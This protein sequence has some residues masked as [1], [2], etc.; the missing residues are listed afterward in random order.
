MLRDIV[1][2]E[3]RRTRWS[4]VAGEKGSSRVRAYEDRRGGILVEF[5]DREPGCAKTKRVRLSL[6]HRD[7]RKAKRKVLEIASGLERGEDIVAEYVTLRQLFDI[8]VREVTPTKG[9]RA[10][11]HDRLCVEMF[12]RCFGANRKVGSLSRR[13]W[14]QFIQLRKKG[15]AGPSDRSVRDRQVEY[16]LKFLRAVCNWATDAKENGKILLA[17]NP[18]SVRSCKLPKEKNPRRPVM[19]EEQYQSLL[20]ITDQFDWRLR[21]ALLLAN[22]TGHRQSAIRKLK[23]SDVDFENQRVCWRAENEKTGYE[24]VTPLSPA[25]LAALLEARPYSSGI[26]DAWVFPSPRWPHRVLS[27]N[28]LD[29][30][31]KKAED[32]VGLPSLGWHSIR[33][34]FATELK[35]VP[36]RDLCALGGWKDPKTVLT[37]YQVPD[38][39]GMRA[40]LEARRSPKEAARNGQTNR[41]T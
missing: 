10:Q 32:S 5:Y 37:C 13:D 20:G 4:Y 19:T 8:Y 33:R 35:D 12:K 30:W 22:E 18:F 21:L 36:L 2:C 40:S 34:K 3:L 15:K 16:D 41:Q 27:R 24:H 1:E 6:G 39:E 23:W 9:T 38:Q 11:Q 14:D 28:A 17:R 25:A 7:R 26:G 29:R 31:L